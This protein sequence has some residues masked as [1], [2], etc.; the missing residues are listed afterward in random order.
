MRRLWTYYK[1]LTGNQKIFLRHKLATQHLLN[2][3]SLGPYSKELRNLSK[4]FVTNIFWTLLS[5]A[6]RMPR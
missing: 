1:L 4:K 5:M 3:E 6:Y 2:G